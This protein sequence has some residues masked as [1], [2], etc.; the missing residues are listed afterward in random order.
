MGYAGCKLTCNAQWQVPP[1]WTST[2]LNAPQTEKLR[3]WTVTM[4][5]QSLAMLS[6]GSGILVSFHQS[7]KR[8]TTHFSNNTAE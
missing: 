8:Q 7:I 6:S 1:L 4:E 3:M 2:L 5:L